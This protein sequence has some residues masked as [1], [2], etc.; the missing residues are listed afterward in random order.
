VAAEKVT[1]AAVKE[2]L[3]DR[4]DGVSKAQVNHVLKELVEEVHDYLTSGYAVNIPGLGTWTP[5]VKPG[6]KK[7]DV[8]RNPFDGTERKL[9]KDEPDKF[10]VKVKK[11]SG[12]AERVFPSMKSKAGQELATQLSKKPKSKAGRRK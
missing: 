9:T 3:L 2:T 1:F 8:V 12:I 10:V 11:P 5:Q 7:G 4:V 6:R